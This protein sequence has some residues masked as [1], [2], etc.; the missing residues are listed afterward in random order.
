[1]EAP[2]TWVLLADQ[3]AEAMAGN[4]TRMLN[5]LL[6]SYGMLAPDLS[7]SSDL[8]RLAVTCLDSPPPAHV[9]ELPTPELLADIGLETIRTVSKH[10]GMS[11]SISE[12]DGGCQF[13]PVRGPERFEGPWN[14]TLSNPILIISNTVRPITATRMVA[15]YSLINCNWIISG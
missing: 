14:H 2:A 12:P 13:W 6:P 3:L 15:D 10:F 5:R 9:S 7:F 8:A 4:G 11:I 1:M